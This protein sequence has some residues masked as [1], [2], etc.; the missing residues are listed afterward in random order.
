MCVTLLTSRC[1]NISIPDYVQFTATDGSDSFTPLNECKIT[2]VQTSE[3]GESAHYTSGQVAGA[4][5]RNV[6]KS[7]T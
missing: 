1:L 3:H 2:L 7:E 6:T 5:F 4:K